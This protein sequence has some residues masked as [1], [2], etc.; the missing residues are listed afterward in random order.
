MTKAFTINRTPVGFRISVENGED[1]SDH[2][3]KTVAEVL[4]HAFRILGLG[5]NTR[6][7]LAFFITDR[8]SNPCELV[9]VEFDATGADVHAWFGGF[10]T[11]AV[12]VSDAGIVPLY[13]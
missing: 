2:Y 3:G 11:S 9:D 4:A 8:F 7:R 13:L 1:S 6:T 12:H 5:E 10:T